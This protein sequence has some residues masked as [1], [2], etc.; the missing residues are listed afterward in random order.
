MYCLVT[1]YKKKQAWVLGRRI[2]KEYLNI[3]VLKAHLSLIIFFVWFAN[4]DLVTILVLGTTAEGRNI[5]ALKVKIWN[6]VT[7][8]F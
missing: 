5:V 2:L 8:F 4:S 6:F 7:D 1:F 3:V